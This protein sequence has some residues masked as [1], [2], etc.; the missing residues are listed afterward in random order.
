MSC[1][2]YGIF[3]HHERNSW[4]DSHHLFVVVSQPEENRNEMKEIELK[5]KTDKQMAKGNR[6]KSQEFK[7]IHLFS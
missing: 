1:M 7:I 6:N 4:M 5:K 2:S 3:V